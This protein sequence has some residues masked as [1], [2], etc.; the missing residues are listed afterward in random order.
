MTYET[1]RN[2]NI[3][4]EVMPRK[5]QDEVNIEEKVVP[6]R[7]MSPKTLHNIDTVECLPQTS[8]NEVQI[9]SDLA[10]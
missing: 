2:V 7:P 4:D 3:V 1:L 8:Q 9:E 6:Y 5:A 10:A